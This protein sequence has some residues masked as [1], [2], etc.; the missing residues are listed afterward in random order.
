MQK[1][2]TL[3]K[4]N[5]R[6]EIMSDSQGWYNISFHHRTWGTADGYAKTLSKAIAI[7]YEDAILLEKGEG[8]S[9][10]LQTKRNIDCGN[11]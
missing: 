2:I 1:I 5:W 7:A 8:H 11:K 4:R 9:Y 6:L 3:V 10:R